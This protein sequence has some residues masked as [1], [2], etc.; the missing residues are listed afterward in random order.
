MSKRTKWLLGVFGGLLLVAL[1]AMVIRTRE[2]SFQGR[3]LSEWLLVY[4]QQREKGGN[5]S[6]TA[7]EAAAAVRHRVIGL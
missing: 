4:T 3:S 5:E 7:K 1:L 6:E 2:P